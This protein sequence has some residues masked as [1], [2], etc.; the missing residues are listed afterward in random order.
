MRALAEIEIGY[1]DF[2]HGPAKHGKSPGLDTHVLMNASCG[3]N[4]R[5]NAW[6]PIYT[7]GP[8]CC[9]AWPNASL[10]ANGTCTASVDLWPDE[11]GD[12][13]PEYAGDLVLLDNDPLDVAGGAPRR[14][15]NPPHCATR[16][17]RA[18]SGDAPRPAVRPLIRFSPPKA[19]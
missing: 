1:P 17:A 18:T 9:Y 19:S 14:V 2:Q 15:L 12:F 10:H 13:K 3:Q 5:S 8:T 11:D 7:I 16:H 6:N 4:T